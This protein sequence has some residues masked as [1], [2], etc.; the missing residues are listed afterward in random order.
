MLLSGE[1][2]QLHNIQMSITPQSTESPSRI[3]SET[4][5]RWK[6]LF[7]KWLR[8]V[9][10]SLI[11]WANHQ[12]LQLLHPFA[13]TCTTGFVATKWVDGYPWLSFLNKVNMALTQIFAFPI[14]SI[15]RMV[16]G[17]SLKALKLMNSPRLRSMPL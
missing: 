8:E 4:K 7:L 1:I 15:A 6:H 10:K 17:R 14:L 16:S 11:P 13:S 3:S 5:K 2:I 12:P 9:K